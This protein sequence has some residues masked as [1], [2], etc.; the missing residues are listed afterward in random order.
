MITTPHA[1]ITDWL[2]L[3][4]D[5]KLASLPDDRARI[6]CLATQFGVWSLKMRRFYD[7]GEQPFNEPHPIYGDMGPADFIILLGMIDGARAKLERARLHA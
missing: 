6:V 1:T 5:K 4:L 3:E 2:Q 7:L